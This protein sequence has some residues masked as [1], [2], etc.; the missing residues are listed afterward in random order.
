MGFVR[1]CTWEGGISGQRHAWLA[2]VLACAGDVSDLGSSCALSKGRIALVRGMV[3]VI[4]TVST[5]VTLASY[6]IVTLAA[7]LSS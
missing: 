5:K 4:Y 3:A 7:S 6:P 2:R 1:V